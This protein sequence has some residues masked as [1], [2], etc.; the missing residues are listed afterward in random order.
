MNL[1]EYDELKHEW[2]TVPYTSVG[3]VTADEPCP[4][5]HPSLVLC[6]VWPGKEVACY[7]EPS[8]DFSSVVGDRC[9][10]EREASTKCATR[11]AIPTMYLGVVNGFKV[12][13]ERGGRSF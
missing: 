5:T 7:C 11:A 6:D 10:D 8:A 9:L 2:E 12:C 3:I 4:A 13:G 1:D